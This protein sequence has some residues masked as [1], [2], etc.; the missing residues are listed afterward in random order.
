MLVGGV[1]LA[2]LNFLQPDTSLQLV[3]ES[4]VLRVCVPTS[5]PPLVTGDS[6]KPGFDVEVLQEIARRLKLR[7]ALNVVPAMGNGYNPRNWSITRSA[8]EVVAGGVTTSDTTRSFLETIP[9]GVENEWVLIGKPG[10]ALGSG[11]KV[12][13]FP[14]YSGLDR[15]KLSAYLRAQGAQITLASSADD[16]ASGLKAGSYDLAITGV[17]EARPVT[18]AEPAYAVTPLPEDLGRYDFGIGLW[19]GD[20]TLKRE[21]AEEYAALEAAGF[22]A[23]LRERYGLLPAGQLDTEAKPGG[24]AA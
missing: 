17:L 22:I 2:A 13:V 18:T 12:G 8:C 19:K 23:G 14:G 4:G 20:L 15:S 24:G 6:I 7:L 10:D 16:L 1:L 5:F 11:R 3:E 21:F 9:I